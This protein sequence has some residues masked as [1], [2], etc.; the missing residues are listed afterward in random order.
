M[1]YDVLSRC[2]L[3]HQEKWKT[4]IF[5]YEEKRSEDSPAS[6]VEVRSLT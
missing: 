2:I 1:E 6:R 5:T 3:A 4:S